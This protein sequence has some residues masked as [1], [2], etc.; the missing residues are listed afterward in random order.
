MGCV[1][2]V[3]QTGGNKRPS[4]SK[5]RLPIRRFATAAKW[6]CTLLTEALQLRDFGASA[7]RRTMG[8]NRTRL[9]ATNLP[10]LS[11]DAS[12][13]GGG[14]VLW[15]EGAPIAYTHFTWQDHSLKI[16]QA[17]LGSCK[18][19]T[20]FEFLTLLSWSQRPLVTSCQTRVHLFEGATWGR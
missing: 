5:H 6:C 14:G 4:S 15:R 11:F 10:T 2:G 3:P 8:N 19:Q 16:V 17:T 18:G 12:P 13:W 7:L 1:C 9:N 20:A